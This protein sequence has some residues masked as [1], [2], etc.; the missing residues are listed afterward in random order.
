MASAQEVTNGYDENTHLPPEWKAWPTAQKAAKLLGC[1]VRHLGRH[2]ERGTIERHQC[3]DN[4][5]RLNPNDLEEAKDQILENIASTESLEKETVVSEGFKS[6]TEL[7][8]QSHKHSEEMFRLYANPIQQLLEMYREENKRK[9]DR[10]KELE[11]KRDELAQQREDLISEQH[12]RDVL[13]NKVLKADARK[14]KAFGMVFDK[15]PGVWDKFVESK[16]GQSREVK[17][18]I[19]LLKGFSRDDLKMLLETDILSPEQKVNVRTILGLEHPIPVVKPDDT[20]DPP[21]IETTGEPG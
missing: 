10:I 6:G 4:V 3:P 11:A 19:E 18:T 13:T 1:S 2:I 15:L 14:D 16:L 9:D 17:A 21:H 7:V 12:M 5:F 20:E 8:K